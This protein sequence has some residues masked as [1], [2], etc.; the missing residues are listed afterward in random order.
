MVFVIKLY[1]GHKII[2][3][4]SSRYIFCSMPLRVFKNLKIIERHFTKNTRT[5]VL[6]NTHCRQVALNWNQQM[7]RQNL[8]L[9]DS[10]SFYF[11]RPFW[12]KKRYY[13]PGVC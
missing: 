6:I 13:L 1:R 5:D 12:N 10:S 2:V 9:F 7:R 4:K 8:K 11:S 3:K